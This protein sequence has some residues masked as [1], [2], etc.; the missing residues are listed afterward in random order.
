MLISLVDNLCCPVCKSDLLLKQYDKTPLGVREGLLICKPCNIVYPISNFI[1]RMVP[2]SLYDS[3]TFCKTYSIKTEALLH[4]WPDCPQDLSSIQSQ[5]QSNFGHEWE[6]YASLGWESN[7][8]DDASNLQESIKWFREK[9]LLDSDDIAGKL[10]LD[11]GCGNGRFSHAALELGA[12]VVSMDLTKAADVAQNNLFG[13]KNVPQVVQGDILHLPFKQEAF[14]IV[15]TLGVIQHTGKA[16]TAVEKL[17]ESLKSKGLLS[18]RT[19]R[20]GNK[21]LE[22][23]DAAIRAVTTQFSLHELHEFSDLLHALT[24]FVIRKGLFGAVARHINIFPKRY[25]IFDWYAA[26]VAEKLT[27]RE[28]RDTFTAIGLQTIRDSDDD[29]TPEDRTF[30]AISIVGQKLA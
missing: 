3:A 4:H 29:T 20:R 9:L 23:N 7:S 22:E 11:A 14:D 2:A 17:A 16:L 24:K 10:I 15:F 12:N 19:Y 28:M 27:Y 1:P 6:H 25:D 26:P 21:R 5:T 18:V 13:T 30:G 8:G